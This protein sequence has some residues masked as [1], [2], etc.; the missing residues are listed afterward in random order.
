MNTETNEH[1]MRQVFDNALSAISTLR[2]RTISTVVSH[3]DTARQL[4]ELRE[5]FDE[6]SNRMNSVVQEAQRFRQDLHLTMVERDKYKQEAMDN[7]SL[8][9]G[10]SKERDEARQELSEARSQ[11]TQ[12]GT[13][14][15]DAQR[16]VQALT[17]QVDRYRAD[18][19]WS[20]RTASQYREE[21]DEARSNLDKIG[22]EL[23]QA[24]DRLSRLQGLM[25]ELFPEAPKPAEAPR[26][27]LA[28]GESIQDVF[29]PR[30]SPAQDSAQP[31][32]DKPSEVQSPSES[33]IDE[34]K[35]SEETKPW[36]DRKD[37]F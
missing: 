23:K 35:P 13:E 22:Q 30:P 16:N 27:Y 6:L 1:E 9:E 18:V 25:R 17:G 37:S 32:E 10:Y 33:P 3:S 5:R 36:W 20:Q 29:N 34:E 24:Q 21:R 11:I 8:A 31:S 12:Y 2:D 14:L 7:A 28:P 19:E 4:S 26:S 15:A